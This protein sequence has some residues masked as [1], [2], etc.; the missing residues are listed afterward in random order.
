MKRRVMIMAAMGAL[1]A[2]I[3]V[4]AD[5]SGVWSG[6]WQTSPTE[7]PSADRPLPFTVPPAT[8]VKGTVRYRM[9]ISQG[10]D[11]V[12]LK[13][14]NE[15]GSAPLLIAAATFGRAADGLNAE[16]G[17][18]RRITF[19]GSPSI[20]IPTGAPVL[21]DPIKVSAI[22]LEDVV[23]SVYVRDGI[24]MFTCSPT[25][26]QASAVAAEGADVTLTERP[27]DSRCMYT[28]R[29][30]V[31]QIEVHSKRSRKVVVTFGDSIT[32]GRVAPETGERGWPGALA[33]RLGDSGIAVVNAGIGG[34][35]LLASLTVFG[36]SALSRLDRDVLTV[37]GL[38]HIVLLEGINDIGM[39][40]PGGMFGDVPLVQSQELIGA[41]LQIIARAHEHRIKVIGGTLL[42]FQGA[43]AYSE[44]REK[45]RTTV[46]EWIRT[47]KQFDGVIDFDAAMRDSDNPL[48]MK[49]DFDSGDH[50]HP[51][52]A[53]YRQ[54]GEIV[55]L[56]LFK[57]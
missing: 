19:G 40:G 50:L 35:R 38:T 27:E 44:D 28:I 2:S 57:Q 53:G 31:S 37:P 12:R 15:M 20:T 11:G 10:G 26:A 48:T 52:F 33:R 32:D 56:R 25:F 43:R 9:R 17:S 18:L 3:A 5:D 1:A 34:N 14:S 21:S 36:P 24:A 29:P 46:N 8:L 16:H 41:Y 4:S 30:V 55:D 49:A 51:N 23:V 22:A 47:S 7:L 39:S 54:M 42:P 45:V 13:F 6:T